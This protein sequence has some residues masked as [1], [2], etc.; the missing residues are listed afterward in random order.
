MKCEKKIEFILKEN[1]RNCRLDSRNGKVTKVR[2][3]VDWEGTAIVFKSTNVGERR[4]V[5]G[6]LIHLLET[7]DRNK[8]LTQED[9]FT[10]LLICLLAT[11]KFNEIGFYSTHTTW[12]LSKVLAMVIIQLSIQQPKDPRL[13]VN[14]LIKTS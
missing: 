3:R 11:I 12:T 14:C 8:S 10:K 13:H 5:E 4:L 6:E 9:S 1:H 2:H 7:F